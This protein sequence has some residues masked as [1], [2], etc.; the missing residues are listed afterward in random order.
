MMASAALRKVLDCPICLTLYTDPVTLRCGHNFCQFCIEEVLKTQDES[1]VYSCI[2][3]KEEFLKRPTLIKN[4]TL[5]NI[6]K[7][8]LPTQSDQ[9][10]T[11]IRCTYC[12]DSPVPAVR[13]CLHCEASLCDNHL[14]V[15]SQGA[16]H[17]LTDPSTS[18]GIRRCS[19]HN[20]ILEYY[21]SNDST[22]ICVSCHL[23]GE[24]KGHKLYSLNEASDE[25]KKKLKNVLQQLIPRSNKTEGRIQCL[26][27]RRGNSQEK[28][29]E[30]I[31]RVTTLFMDIRGRVDDLEKKI[32]GE[33]S[34][35]EEHELLSLS[36]LIQK[37][38]MQKDELSR[39]M[40]HIEELCNMTDP[41]TVLQ[42]PN[43]E[44]LFH[45]KEEG[46]DEGKKRRNESDRVAELLSRVSHALSDIIRGVNVTFYVQ[47]PA[48]ILLNVDTADNNLLISDDL[49]TATCTNINQNRPETAARFRYCNQVMSSGR[50]WSG[51]HYWDVEMK[52]SMEWSVGM[53]Y[54]SI[55]RKGPQSEIG[56]NDQ[57]W[58]LYGGRLCNTQYSV[59]HEREVTLLPHRI[60]S[61]IIRICLDF[62]A[63]QLSFYELCDPIRHLYTFYATF[64]KP[65]HAA[66]GVLNGSVKFLGG[67]G[68]CAQLS[69]RNGGHGQIQLVGQSAS[70]K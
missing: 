36:D 66:I 14:R 3:C 40:R 30:E 58:C 70:R 69:L 15:H 17:V 51:R 47:D 4:Q 46:G 32:L 39:K 37:L 35:L 6:V 25:R 10:I 16:G 48:D 19:V 60:T 2:E 5:C 34:R 41:L 61:D 7:N 45:L 23:I 67:S 11:G 49:K 43:I 21:C 64:T 52:A 9:E 68:S 42:E 8:F 62:E 1:G 28:A 59:I 33:L 22:C 63:G 57:S 50:F 44:D 53:C 55:D 12:V 18:L 56:E 65:L 31:L 54:S 26:E 24:H 20:K 27:E 29:A 13:S 38:E